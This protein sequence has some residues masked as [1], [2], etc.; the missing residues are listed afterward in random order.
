MG[1][2]TSVSFAVLINGV[3]S[4]FFKGQRG[5]RQGCPLL[6]L[7]FLLV[8]RGLSQLVLTV[9]WEGAIRGLEVVVNMFISHLL[10]VDNIL[11]FSN[12]NISEI[13]ELKR[14]LE[15]FMKATGMQVNYRKSQLILKGFNRHLESKGIHFLNQVEKHGH[16]TIWGQ[17]WQSGEELDLLPH[18]W[19]DWKPYTQELS[20]SN[21]RLK[22]RPDQL[23][24]AYVDSGSYIPKFGYKF[25]MSKNG[26]GNPKWWAEHLWN[27]AKLFFWC[28]LK[29]K[30]PTWDILQTRYKSRPGRCSLCKN[31]SET[32]RNLFIDCPIIKKVWLEVGKLI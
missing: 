30:V 8:A 18:W 27:I 5:L 24:W 2:I 29:R 13:K 11:L 9:E 20:R 14:I 26:W 25:L 21:V 7:L 15:L 28:I 12:G 10:F 19:N 32:I 16:S 17:A 23:V 3:A 1:C 31:E 6:P 4:S 22:D